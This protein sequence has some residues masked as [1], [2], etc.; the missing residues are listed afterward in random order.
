M[1]LRESTGI[2]L[3]ALRANKLRSFLTL[4][5]T[6]IGVMAVIAVMSLVHGLN[7]YVSQKLLN[8]GANVFWVDPYGFVTSQ[9][10]WDKVKDRPL[11]TLDDAEALSAGLGPDV[12]IVAQADLTERIHYKDREMRA[13]NI[14]GRGPGWEIVEDYP[15]ASG[16]N[17]SE[18]DDARRQLVCVIGSEVADELFPSLD[19]LGH[20]IRVGDETYEVV[21]VMEAKGKLLGQPQDRFVTIPMRTFQ[22]FK[23]QRGSIQIA[24]KSPD[25]ASMPT[26]QQ[27]VR[28][29]LRGRRHLGPLRPD[30]FGIT[31]SDN[32]MQLYQTIMGGIFVVTIGVAGISLFVGAIV[33]MNIMLVSVTE[34]TR[35]IGVRKAMGARRRDILTQFLVEAATLSVSGGAV[36]IVGGALVAVLV[37]SVFHLPPGVSMPAIVLGIVMSVGIGVVSGSYPAWRAAGLDPV[38]AL[39]YE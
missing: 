22:K 7:T 35:E 11:I 13:I 18:L 1:N 14:R 3:T 9:E 4:L 24:V 30:N 37:L 2:A 5:G 19:A 39:R 28:N 23:Q 26:I 29:I 34:R 36:G 12:M 20:R 17:L 16:R 10:E 27:E 21:G 25:Q 8:A 32:V 33:I 31:T 15:I 38:E 6:I